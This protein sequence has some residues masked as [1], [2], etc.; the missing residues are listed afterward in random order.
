MI[1]L[2]FQDDYLFLYKA[3][4]SLCSDDTSLHGDKDSGIANCNNYSVGTHQ[5]APSSPGIGPQPTTPNSP[6]QPNF[7][8][9]SKTNSPKSPKSAMCPESTELHPL[10]PLLDEQ[11]S[12]PLPQETPP[13]S[14]TSPASSSFM[15]SDP[16]A[17]SSD[18]TGSR[19]SN[20][21]TGSNN[22]AADC[23]TVP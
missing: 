12:S 4:E 11:P 13:A 16:P 21:P 14:P 17:L 18:A 23:P 8:S 2:F 1:L 15:I 20:P 7:I 19:L 22:A 5:Q 3:V 6:S 9:N 10:T